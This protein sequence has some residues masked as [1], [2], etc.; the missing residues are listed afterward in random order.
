MSILVNS[1]KHIC[2][3]LVPLTLDKSGRPIPG[4]KVGASHHSTVISQYQYQY[5]YRE[6]RKAS[7]HSTNTSN[8]NTNTNTSD[9]SGRPSHHSTLISRC[10][11]CTP[12]YNTLCVCSAGYLCTGRRAGMSNIFPGKLSAL[13]GGRRPVTWW[14]PA[15]PGGSPGTPNHWA[16]GLIRICMHSLY[17]T[18]G[19]GHFVRCA[20]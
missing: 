3:K 7:H 6:A 15:C 1:H 12:P 10:P 2:T 18:C 4:G 11:S 20:P 8:I 19:S 16:A 5:Q 13:C 14:S 9:R 17:F